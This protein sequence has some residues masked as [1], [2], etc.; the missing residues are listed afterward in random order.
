MLQHGLEHLRAQRASEH[1]VGRGAEACGGETL[2]VVQ[3]ARGRW[4][5]DLTSEEDERRGVA[6]HEALAQHVGA[7]QLPCKHTA[8]GSAKGGA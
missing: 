1:E 8:V 2:R 6:K 5:T 4:R 3:A 7:A